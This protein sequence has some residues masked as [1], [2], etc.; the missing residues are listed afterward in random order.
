MAVS[1]S[2]SAQEI[3]TSLPLTT[4]GDRLMWSLGDQDLNL[5]VPLDGPVRLELYSPRLA[6]S[7]YRADTY[8]GDE[9]YDAGRP[10][11]TT[12]FTVVRDDGT[13][14]L[15]RTFT[16]GEHSWE[17]LLNQTLPAG[18]Y[19][20]RAATE[21]S[22][23]NTFAIRLAGVSAEVS[24]EQISVNVHSRDW[25]PAVNVTTDGRAH[26]LRL[27][28]GDGPQELQAR[29]RDA[30]GNVF[31]LQVSA[32]LNH[33]DLPLPAKA[34][35]YT[36]ELRQPATA[37][38]FSN[39][40]G[41]SLVR[42]GSPAP[43][44]V[45]RVDQ[46]GTLRVRAELV[47]PGETRST[48]A[49]VTL[50]KT[51]VTI[52]GRLERRVVAGT[53]PVTAA[54]VAGAQVTVGTSSVTV[55][56]DGTGETLVQI[57][58]SVGLDLQ[59]DKLE[60]CQGDTVTVT[61]RAVTAFA[62][63]LPLDLSLSAPGLDS[64][65]RRA[66]GTLSAAQPGQVTLTA[67][68]TRPGPLTVTA[69]LAP[70]G[71]ERQ[72]QLN[73]L[74]DTT[75]LQVQRETP[76]DAQVGEEIDVSLRV[77][78]TAAQPVTYRVQDTPAAGLDALS[79]TAFTGT[80][81][82]GETRTLRYRARVTQAGPLS[83]NAQVSSDTCS[84]VQTASAQLTAEPAPTAP[85][86][87][88]A[89]TPAPA[90]AA[91][92]QA[93]R[94]STVSLPFDAPRQSTEL[95]IA[96]PAT[97]GA[98][99]I[100]G[101]ARLNGQPLTDPVRGPSGT[102]YWVVIPTSAM[103]ATSAAVRGTVTYDLTHTEAL[104]E[105]GEPALL[106]RFKGER[107]E[108]LQGQLD[109]QDL[110]AARPLDSAEALTENDGAIKF[111][112]RG[113]L[114]RLRDRINVTVEVPD[115]QAAALTVNGQEISTDRIGETTTDPARGVRRLTYV[116]VPLKAGQNTLQ[117]GNDTVSVQLVGATVRTEVTPVNLTADGAT[118]LRVKLRTLDAN[119]NLSAQGSVTVT[120]NLE[121][122]NADA[123][124][125][126]SGYQVRLING[127]GELVL[128]PQSAPTTLKL[129]V[130]Q[131]QD[132]RTY[133]F[134]VKPD[135][136]R[137]GVG[138]VSATLGLDGSL[139][140][141][142]DLTWQARA[143]YEGPLAGGKLYVAANKDGLPTDTDP[144]KRFAAYGD[145]STQAVALQGIDP[146]GIR[147]DH[148][149]FRAEYRRSSLPI[150]VLPVREQLTALTVS[151]KSTPQVSGFAALV[152]NDRVHDVLVP[153][154]TRLL[155]L[156]HGDVSEGSET[157]E[158]VTLERGT[159]K[160]LGH[161]TL[162]RNVDY[163]LDTRTGIITLA[164]TLDHVD[165]SL[166]DLRVQ[167]TYRLNS[168]LDQR[169]LAYGAQVKYQA[170]QGSVGVAAVSLDGTVT[171]GARA[172]YDN[173]T[174]RA[175]GLLAYSSGFQ[176]S[177]DFSTS[178]G[179]SAI[180]ARVRYQDG[181]Y[182]GLAP[183]TA[184]LTAS[185][186]V[187]TRLTTS[188]SSNVQAEYHDT[189]STADT[190]TQGGSVTAR[191]DYRLAPFSVGA[192][193]KYAFGDQYGV[194]AVISA[195]YHQAPVDID[196]RHTQP[197]AGAAGGN[198]TPVTSVSARYA[199][200]DTVTVGVTDEINWTTGHNAALTLSS[201]LGNT[202]YQ[203]AYD[204]PTAGGQGNRA[205]FGVSTTSALTDHLTAGLRGSATY[206]IGS[207]SAEAGAG[208][209]LNYK[210]DTLSATVGT[211]L[212]TG[213]RGFGVVLRGG[214]SGSLGEHLTLTADGLVEFGAGKN[215]Q[216]AALGFAYRDRT[217][218][219]LGTVRYVN[220]TLAGN[221]PELSS[222]LAAEYRQP[223]WSV[224]AG[225][226]TRTMLNDSDSFTA[227]LGLGGTYYVNDRV[228]IGAWGRVLTQPGTS[229]TQYG[230]GLE[231]SVRALP[232]T[233]ITAGYNP[234]GFNGLGTSYTRQGAYLRVDLTLD[235]STGQK[236]AQHAE[237]TGDS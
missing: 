38:Q 126:E 194:G 125:G 131:G 23:K 130:Q 117:F 164:R 145:A 228:G 51:P 112:L 99:F 121:P 90:E 148:P 63:D 86:L 234:V 94:V 26:T 199:L 30:Q 84:A 48:R 162:Q 27:Y 54:P 7:D 231:A 138:V 193:V 6:P 198:L 139:S 152:P 77:T 201:R 9:Q 115:D 34:G 146:I 195:G 107:S 31:P 120:S 104:D 163:V 75:S 157:L 206:D 95:V 24:A 43:I 127:E 186:S 74:P 202:N 160:D 143:S 179:R 204:L 81:G 175:D 69:R 237:S 61:A 209:D 128:Q 114:I 166:N 196:V 89:V 36:V 213:D 216:R 177:A 149:S 20:I 168:A 46:T 190:R 134:D 32:D 5:E 42:D 113:S 129:N 82:A 214:V 110:A 222:N 18:R 37:Q 192:G 67:T 211:D 101:S 57:R 105:L 176:A 153:E 174:T 116:G 3:S 58:P 71:E 229:T 188:L 108:T 182:E 233:W 79:D 53:Y 215:G 230:Y 100:P 72:L 93:Q 151:S 144:Q 78:N 33:T 52:D 29:L 59:A 40:V 154:N 10:Q 183:F 189:L 47:L 203:V 73:V 98:T 41:F 22:G 180:Q 150:D 56:R 109:L 225:V 2:A 235:D 88:E 159:G 80:L 172:T 70:W 111:P 118:P 16:P 221:Q 141:G 218:N 208:A 232:G 224:R 76:A 119:G 156:T 66:Q 21:G 85:A 8:Y 91:A 173:G 87:A 184:G 124:P 191:A 132:T 135:S 64:E 49:A 103:T 219:A 178:L 207:K 14:L 227:Q 161:V 200:T 187:D 60:V 137:V 17:T 140:L 39:T 12:T 185:A 4:V 155:R 122:R 68:A 133:T 11:V 223:T 167:A 220:G 226:D 50:G 170:A 55:P 83:L 62:G 158:V 15:T 212:T 171:A 102:L 236:P 136:S 217:F 25:V 210:T 106:A 92:P 13:I 97:T 123:L 45:A 1:V 147:Y 169:K 44:T 181:T 65:G 96:H 28:D 142:N 197:L 35:T 205:R 19:R 165:P